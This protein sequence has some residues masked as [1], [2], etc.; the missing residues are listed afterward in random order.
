MVS[1]QEALLHSQFV[2]LDFSNKKQKEIHDNVVVASRKIY[3]INAELKHNP[4]KHVTTI[5]QDEKTILI[6]KIQD[7]IER[8]YR[9]EF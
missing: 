2:E 4:S 8:V 3:S 9:L 5:L 1:Q 6:K 7:L